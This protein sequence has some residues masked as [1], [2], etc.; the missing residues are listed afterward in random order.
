M[1]AN[2]YGD[3]VVPS[4]STWATL[5]NPTINITRKVTSNDLDT[6]DFLS[7][8][9][10]TRLTEETDKKYIRTGGHCIFHHNH[11]WF[12]FYPYSSGIN[13]SYDYERDDDFK[14]YFTIVVKNLNKDAIY[15]LCLD[16]FVSFHHCR[17]A[18][19]IKITS[20]Y[21]DENVLYHKKSEFHK[22]TIEGVTGIR[23]WFYGHTHL[24]YCNKRTYMRQIGWRDRCAVVTSKWIVPDLNKKMKY[25][26][27]TE[28]T[29]TSTVYDT[30]STTTIVTEKLI[31]SHHIHDHVFHGCWRRDHL[32]HMIWHH[33]L[34]HIEG[35]CTRGSIDIASLDEDTY[36][37]V[38][39]EGG[40]FQSIMFTDGIAGVSTSVM[41]DEVIPTGRCHRIHH[42]VLRHMFHRG[43]KHIYFCLPWHHRHCVIKYKIYRTIKIPPT[44]VKSTIPINLVVPDSEVPIISQ[45]TV[46]EAN[47]EVTNLGVSGYVAGKSKLAIE[48]EASS[49]IN[50]V[51]ELKYT[52]TITGASNSTYEG[53][54]FTTKTIE[55]PGIYRIDVFVEDTRGRI[56]KSTKQIV[57]L[58]IYEPPKIEGFTVVRCD[59]DGNK[60]PNEP[61]AKI[62]CNMVDVNEIDGAGHM[63]N[64]ILRGYDVT[65][66]TEIVVDRVENVNSHKVINKIV[67]VGYNS[68]WV[69]EALVTD[70]FSNEISEKVSLSSIEY[71]KP[72]VEFSG[73]RC[74][75]EGHKDII[76]KYAK[77]NLKV[78]IGTDDKGNTK[79]LPANVK[80]LYR[81]S[82]SNAAYKEQ[83]LKESVFAIFE[84][85]LILSIDN[86]NYDIVL[87]VTDSISEERRKIVIK[88]GT[89]FNAYGI[90][91]DGRFK[92]TI[93]NIP[94]D[95]RGRVESLDDVYN[96][97]L[98]YNG[99]I[100]YNMEDETHY[101]VNTLGSIES[102]G[103]NLPNR[104]VNTYR[105]LKA[106]ENYL[107]NVSYYNKTSFDKKLDELRMAINS[108]TESLD[109]KL[110]ID[111]VKVI[112]NPND[113]TFNII[114]HIPRLIP[115]EEPGANYRIFRRNKVAPTT[116]YT[117]YSVP[118]LI[119]NGFIGGAVDKVIRTD[120]YF[121]YSGTYY[122]PFVFYICFGDY[123]TK[124]YIVE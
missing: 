84:K 32:G 1:S 57:V 41:I 96:I 83:I 60:N 8:E 16:T 2:F 101:V 47:K 21:D 42:D 121:V 122:E 68:D 40:D 81:P 85:E 25:L 66:G 110:E 55:D 108:L 52:T 114:W 44:K 43:C 118:E 63:S 70:A 48:I 64:F 5:T 88:A 77:V 26:T 24:R 82:N 94:D 49:N 91:Y 120:E 31:H 98:P 20:L 100:F 71:I 33:N 53:R 69:F 74:G 104:V 54:K 99:L 61:C 105:K 102:N 39:V 36:I 9:I 75:P 103:L 95:A 92:P 93:V 4:K 58:N 37:D 22:L 38:E 107:N 65:K 34:E 86:V 28:G 97:P 67:D 45:F 80:I 13:W 30:G 87:V 6:S 72:T 23:I 90:E 11:G 62:N 3:F 124:E 50:T 109:S 12:G 116:S 111:Y 76:G 117:E 19:T 7:S 123:K 119:T 73:F 10:V 112:T 59:A 18:K 115:G 14:Y 29:I 27:S 17:G 89:D 78:K 106:D 46:K 113:G 35:P 79:G 15:E 56:S 51:D